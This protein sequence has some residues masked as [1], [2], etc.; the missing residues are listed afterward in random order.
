MVLLNSTSQ[1]TS[2]CADPNEKYKEVLIIPKEKACKKQTTRN[3][4]IR[5]VQQIMADNE[6]D[7][8]ICTINQSADT[9]ISVTL[10]VN[11]ANWDALQDAAKAPKRKPKMNV[12]HKRNAK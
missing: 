1:L 7:K 9:G 2:H 8:A 4:Y 11:M 12:Q 5:P 6:K 10:L 3:R